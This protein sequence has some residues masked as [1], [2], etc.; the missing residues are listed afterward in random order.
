MVFNCHDSRHRSERYANPTQEEDFVS[1][2]YH[3]DLLTAIPIAEIVDLID[4]AVTRID[5]GPPFPENRKLAIKL[6]L[7]ARKEI[8]HAVNTEEGSTKAQKL[9]SWAN[10]ARTM[11]EIQ[12]TT[13]L[14]MAIPSA[15]S[16]KIQRHLASSVPPRYVINITFDE[17]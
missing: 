5:S 4:Q 11:S 15:F 14:G 2:L 10:C 8:L 3:R 17:A 9:E 1:N 13:S 12:H 6:R 7:E 16:Y